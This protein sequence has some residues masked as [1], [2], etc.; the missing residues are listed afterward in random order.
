L[1][2]YSK[3]GKAAAANGQAE[4]PVV[5]SDEE[6]DSEEEEQQADKGEE[7]GAYSRPLF[8]SISAFCGIGGAFRG[9]LG[10]VWEFTGVRM[11]RVCFVPETAEVELKSG[12]V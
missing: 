6:A 10:G 2:R 3:V 12:R 1:R 5:A 7:A 4:T 8:G 11:F 9:C